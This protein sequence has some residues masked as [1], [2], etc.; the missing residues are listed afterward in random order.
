MAK[1]EPGRDPQMVERTRKLNVVFAL[2]SIALLIVFSL[3]IWEDYDRDWKK[4]QIEFN[5]LEVK[6]TEQDIQAA[7]GKVD[8]AKRKALEEQ[9]ARGAEEKKARKKDIDRVQG[10]IDKLDGEWY[11]VDED[12]RVTKAKIDVAR[13]EYEEADHAGAKSAD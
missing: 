11:R 6:R 7:L 9:L 1:V 3:M 8:A 13:Y 4:H 10:E 5:K 2:T 12:Y